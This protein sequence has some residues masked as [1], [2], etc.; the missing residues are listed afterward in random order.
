MRPEAFINTFH[1]DLYNPVDSPFCRVKIMGSYRVLVWT[2]YHHAYLL[3][4]LTI[5]NVLSPYFPCLVT[6]TLKKK[7]QGKQVNKYKAS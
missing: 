6:H 5:W 7:N 3:C 1:V 4:S 2:L